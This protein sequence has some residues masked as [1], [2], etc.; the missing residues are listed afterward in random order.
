MFAIIQVSFFPLWKA[1]TAILGGRAGVFQVHKN[2]PVFIGEGYKIPH[3]KVK[4]RQTLHLV[5]PPLVSSSQLLIA[6]LKLGHSHS[7][8]KSCVL[9]FSKVQVFSRVA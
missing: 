6:W 4:V 1:Q 8:E 3:R 7:S 5:L 9:S 2:T